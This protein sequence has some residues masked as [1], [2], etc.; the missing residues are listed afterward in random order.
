MPRFGSWQARQKNPTILYHPSILPHWGTNLQHKNPVGANTISKLWQ[1]PENITKQQVI[2]D[3][4]NESVLTILNSVIVSILGCFLILVDY[5][6][7]F[8][9]YYICKS[10]SSN[11]SEHHTLVFKYMCVFLNPLSPHMH[12]NTRGGEEYRG[13]I[14][15]KIVK[16]S[17][18]FTNSEFE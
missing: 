11:D 9:G 18:T 17:K 6:Q 8:W 1:I 3:N 10:H 13:N 4:I 7:N 2:T 14:T 5:T 15:E 16:N 12:T